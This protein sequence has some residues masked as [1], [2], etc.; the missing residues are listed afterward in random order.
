MRKSIELLH[1][2][3][4]FSLGSLF[5]V[6][7]AVVIFSFR[8]L[9]QEVDAESSRQYAWVFTRAL[10][11]ARTVYSANVANRMREHGVP[12]RHDYKDHAAAIPNPATFTIELADEVSIED[13]GVMARLYSDYPFKGRVN[14]GLRDG[15]ERDALHH[16]RE[17]PDTPFWRIEERSG[18]ESLRYAQAITM[19]QSCV[20]CHNSHPQSPRKDWRVG[21]V[22][23]VHEI[24]LPL[25]STAAT[26]RAGVL[27]T[28]LIMLLLTVAG[29]GILASVVG[30]LRRS[31]AAERTAL[32]DSQRS[33]EELRKTNQAVQRFVPYAFLEVIERVSVRDV[34][35]GDSTMREMEVLFCDLRSFTTLVEGMN[36]SE[37]YALLNAYL[38]VMEPPIHHE[39]GFI[40][41]YLG[42]S[43]MALFP[44]GPDATLRAT[45]GMLSGM[46]QFNTG[47]AERG[48]SP[49][50]VGVGISAGPL[51]LG[52]LGGGYR[53]DQGVVGDDVNLA[54]RL[55]G[56]NK[57]YGSQVLIS[58]QCRARLQAPDNF[59]IR[60]LDLARAK[61]KNRAVRIHEL[62][63]GL[64]EEQRALRLRTASDFA[65]GLRLYRGQHF[66]EAQTQFAKCL[67]V[68]PQDGAAQLYVARCDG[69]L[70][71][72]PGEDWD[73]VTV[74]TC[75]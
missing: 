58:E 24:A 5:V 18:V 10:D 26:I 71:D 69:M 20:D 50:H 39:G 63:D 30:R 75:K 35:P 74:F 33:N 47:R 65:E 68:D 41:Q 31:L 19:T 64:P 55:E 9:S 45:V 12:V 60:E 54:S 21:E 8:T 28:T 15:F 1:R 44:S 59:E 67:E 70:M 51:M 42:D 7:T 14:G 25:G 23:G 3:P 34:E 13:Y 40:N 49:L 38:T 52:T 11:K 32:R 62:L 46:R 17:R 57:V 53:L 37:A 61:G 27:T 16:L 36:P 22:R 2:H 43:I 48:Q 6:G 72:S 73:G 66:S 4:L 29:L 56:L